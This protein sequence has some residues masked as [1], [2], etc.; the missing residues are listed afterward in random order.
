M[1]VNARLYSKPG[2]HLC[3]QALADLEQLQKRVPHV[4]E[5]VDISDDAQLM[6]TYGERI[7]VLSVGEREYSAPLGKALLEQ[8]LREAASAPRREPI[9]SDRP[10]PASESHGR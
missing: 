6:S 8:A 7:P 5:L 3:E 10:G 4:L 9:G 2:C 1:T